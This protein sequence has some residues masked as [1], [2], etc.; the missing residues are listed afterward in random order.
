MGQLYA[1]LPFSSDTWDR[2]GKLLSVNEWIYWS[3]TNV[4]PYQA[5]H[6]LAWVIDRLVEYD[7]AYD[8]V[9]CV[10]Y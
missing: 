9:Y 8:A 6:K 7:R 2:I 1:N 4:N 10:W 3:K 5:G